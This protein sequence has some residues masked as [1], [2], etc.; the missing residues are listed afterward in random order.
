MS[1]LEFSLILECS[2]EIFFDMQ[3]RYEY[4]IV[5]IVCLIL[6]TIYLLLPKNDILSYFH[7]EK[8][9]KE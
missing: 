4:S 3:I 8:F 9:H 1:L 7:N 6:G 5:S 2:G